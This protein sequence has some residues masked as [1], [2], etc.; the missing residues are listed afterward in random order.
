MPSSAKT[1]SKITRNIVS[2]MEIP[3]N[4]IH[5]VV[6]SFKTAKK[7]DKEID[8]NTALMRML[9]SEAIA[10]LYN[11]LHPSE[12]VSY[13]VGVDCVPDELLGVAMELVQF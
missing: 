3:K 11:N 6:E 5:K 13:Y 12:E 2:G 8:Q 9:L 1:K 7:I 4:V 10:D